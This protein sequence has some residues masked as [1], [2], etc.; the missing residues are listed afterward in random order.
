MRPVKKGISPYISISCYQNARKYLIDQIGEYCSYC[1]RRLNVSLA[2]EH[3]LPKTIYQKKELVWE[4]LILACTNCN[5]TKG[6]KDIDLNDYFWPHMDNTLTPYV[7][8]V[9][10]KINIKEGLTSR[11]HQMADNLIKLVGLNSQPRRNDTT[12]S[13][14]LWAFREEVW[15]DAEDFK[16][17]LANSIDK[18]N[19]R[20]AIVRT[21][22]YSGCFSI[23]IEVFKDDLETVKLLID[24]FKNT[25][26]PNNVSSTD[27]IYYDRNDCRT[28][29][30]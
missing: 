3:I 30:E 23:W 25:A 28:I 8:T 29:L 15:R 22:K 17:D 24:N 27:E 18:N 1:E 4:N 26:L 9:S 11:R 16:L 14:R 10:G 2:V 7:Y 5:S 12:V 21:A 13:D 19:M 6:H 20:K